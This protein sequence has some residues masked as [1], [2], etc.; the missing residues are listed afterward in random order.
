MSMPELTPA[1]VTT[2][3]SITTRSLVGMAPWRARS[4]R[5]SQ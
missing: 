3:P 1:A 4:S 5:A 2:L